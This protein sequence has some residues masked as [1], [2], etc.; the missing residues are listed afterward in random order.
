[1]NKIM[2][3]FNAAPCKVI[4]VL[5]GVTSIQQEYPNGEVTHLRIVSADFPSL[6]RD[7]GMVYVASDTPLTYQEI[8]DAA[9]KYL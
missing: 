4:S 5:N 1:M 6:T 9:N 2:V 3:F 7:H 8:L